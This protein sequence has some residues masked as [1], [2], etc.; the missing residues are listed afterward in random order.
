MGQDCGFYPGNIGGDL[1]VDVVG[2]INMILV[3]S[4]NPSR[5]LTR[6]TF[7]QSPLAP[8][9]TTPTRVWPSSSSTVRGP[10]LSTW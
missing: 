7:S 3:N 5:D 6:L 10:P 4:D 1:G 2:S 8:W 9:L